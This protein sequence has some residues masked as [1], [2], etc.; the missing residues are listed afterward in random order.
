MQTHRVQVGPHF[1]LSGDLGDFGEVVDLCIRVF[2]F[3]I[4]DGEREVSPKERIHLISN[5][6]LLFVG[7]FPEY[8]VFGVWVGDGVRVRLM[9]GWLALRES[10]ILGWELAGYIYF[11]IRL[12]PIKYYC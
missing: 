8:W 5:L 6:K 12:D 9:M 4:S 11:L 2:S 7:C 3:E 10:K 1:I